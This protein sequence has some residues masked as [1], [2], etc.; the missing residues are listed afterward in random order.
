[1]LWGENVHTALLPFV[2]LGA[3]LPVLSYWMARQINLSENAALFSAA[4]TA[5]LPEFVIYSLRTDTVIP[6]ALFT[7]SSILLL[8]DGLQKGGVL[9]FI[10]SGLCA[11]LAYLTRNDGV[12]LLPMFVVTLIVYKRWRNSASALN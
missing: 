12:L 8:T 5:V 7:C 6:C 3:L 4:M 10:G 1:R 2:F 11:G 9:C